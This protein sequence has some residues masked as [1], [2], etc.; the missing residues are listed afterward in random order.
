MYDR[1][2]WM[3]VMDVVREPPPQDSDHLQELMTICKDGMDFYLHAARIV[4][5]QGVKST[6]MEIAATRRSIIEDLLREVSETGQQPV[7]NGSMTFTLRKW[8]ADAQ[9]FVLRYDSA[10]FLEQLLAV[11]DATLLHFERAR[12]DISNPDWVM[13]LV[14]CMTT[15]RQTRDRLK[16]LYEDVGPRH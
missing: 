13:H 12:E 16:A 6:F 9:H 1:H 3:P 2:Y 7:I 5:H 15:F 4:E 11:E 10:P 14:G 8:Y